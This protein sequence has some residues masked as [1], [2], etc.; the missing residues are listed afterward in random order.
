MWGNFSNDLFHVIHRNMSYQDVTYLNRKVKK[1][2][3]YKRMIN[4][5]FSV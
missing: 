4:I 3:H 1:E 2:N 5:G